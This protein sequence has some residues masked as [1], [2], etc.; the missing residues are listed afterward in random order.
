MEIAGNGAA[1]H[2]YSP[3]H[4]AWTGE[5]LASAVQDIRQALSKTRLAQ[6]PLWYTKGGPGPAP[7]YF[8]RRH[9]PVSHADAAL[10]QASG[11]VRCYLACLANGAD[12]FFAYTL[13]G[14]GHWS[15]SWAIMG[16][17]DTLPP[18]MP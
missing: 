7:H 4:L 17:D 2:Y 9:G 15:E 18:R 16:Y 3:Q 8:Y 6:A 13:H 14:T 10:D 11:Q 5:P 12:K 1:F